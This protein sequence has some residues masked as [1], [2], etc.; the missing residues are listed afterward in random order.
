[1]G[2]YVN[3]FTLTKPSVSSMFKAH[4]SDSYIKITENSNRLRAKTPSAIRIVFETSCIACENGLVDSWARAGPPFFWRYNSVDGWW[5]L[6]FLGHMQG[7]FVQP[8][9][10]VTRPSRTVE[11]GR[12]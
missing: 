11:R 5:I 7:R 3:S 1:M 12:V 10:E 4:P 9:T 8:P 2:S 6:S